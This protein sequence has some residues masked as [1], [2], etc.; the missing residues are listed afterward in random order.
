ME[1][2]TIE[3]LHKD[4]R[5]LKRDMAFIKHVLTE[6]AEL[7]EEVKKRLHKVRKTSMSEYVEL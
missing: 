6:K 1:T 5:E 4:L 7:S 2:V 3:H